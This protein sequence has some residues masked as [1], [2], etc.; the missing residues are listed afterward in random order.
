MKMLTTQARYEGRHGRPS[1]EDEYSDDDYERRHDDR[2]RDRSKRRHKKRDESDDEPG[3][4]VLKSV[5]KRFSKTE[6][7]LQTGAI[8][9]TQ[10]SYIPCSDPF[11][12]SHQRSASAPLVKV[13]ASASTSR[14]S[15]ARSAP[16]SQR[17]GNVHNALS[18]TTSLP[19]KIGDRLEHELG[20]KAERVEEK[21]C[22]LDCKELQR[23]RR[24]IIGLICFSRLKVR[25]LVLTWGPRRHCWRSSG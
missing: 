12:A 22:R 10:P 18:K 14:P 8:G 1:R 11:L 24:A 20:D 2:R 16:L 6:K 19:A 25:S 4:P 3:N 21:L 17:H 23:D 15:S 9:K 5:D 7:G 13:P